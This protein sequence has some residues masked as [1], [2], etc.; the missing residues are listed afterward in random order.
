MILAMCM[1]ALQIQ[2]CSPECVVLVTIEKSILRFGEEGVVFLK[3]KNISNQNQN[4]YS[5]NCK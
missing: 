5:T 2:Q 1:S 4:I 3:L